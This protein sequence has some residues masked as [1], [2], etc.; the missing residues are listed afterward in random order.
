[1]GD[2]V[3]V[4]QVL[5]EGRGPSPAEGGPQTGDRGGVSYP[6]LVLDLDGAQR[7]EQLLDEVV[8][9]VVEGGAAETGEP[10]RPPQR[11]ALLVAVLPPPG[12]RGDHPVGDHLHRPVEWQLLPAGSVG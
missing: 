11:V 3:G 4:G 7:G 12:P 2:D 10:Q 6:G 9:L 1:D 5:L 8:L